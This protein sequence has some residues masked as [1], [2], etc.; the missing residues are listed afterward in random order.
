MTEGRKSA[1]AGRAPGTWRQAGTGVG[2]TVGG[3][4]RAVEM[5]VRAITSGTFVAV[6]A[7]SK[8]AGTTTIVPS[9]ILDPEGDP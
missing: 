8:A 7:L 6:F 2:L 3:G 1:G 4:G 9:R 5:A